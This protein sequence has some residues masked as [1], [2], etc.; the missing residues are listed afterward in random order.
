LHS[1]RRV[2]VVRVR[3]PRLTADG[4]SAIVFRPQRETSRAVA[5]QPHEE[6]FRISDPRTNDRI[7]VRAAKRADGLSRAATRALS[8]DTQPRFASGARRNRNMEPAS[9]MGLS[10]PDLNRN[11][12]CVKPD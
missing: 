5:E 6:E 4:W 9:A 2:R 7:R 10:A 11:K 3:S 1:A 8:S 12:R